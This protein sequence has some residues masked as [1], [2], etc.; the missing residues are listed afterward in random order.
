LLERI[1]F[2]QTPATDLR[3]AR[4]EFLRTVAATLPLYYATR[5]PTA[6]AAA[7]EA[8]AR[9]IPRQKNPD[10]LEFPFGTLKNF[11]TPNDLFYVRNHF[12]A[13]KL[14]AMTWRLQVEGHVEKP[15][16]LGYEELLGLPPS[17]LNATLECAGNGRAFLAPKTKGVQWEQGAVSTAAWTGVKLATLLERAGVKHDAVEVVLEGADHGEPSN[18]P[19]PPGGIHFARSLPLTKASS[20]SVLLAYKMNGATLPAL[21]GFPVRAVVGGWYGMASVKWLTRILVT[22]RPFHGYDQS[23]DY[24]IW[25]RVSGVPSLTP[26][27]QMQVKAAIAR[28]TVGEQ[29]PAHRKYRVHGA[30]W[31]GEADVGRVEVSTDGGTTWNEARLRGQALPLCWRLWDFSWT[32]HR[33]GKHAL[34]ARATDNRGNVQPMKHDPDRRNYMITKVQPC[35]VEVGS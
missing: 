25:E 2:M 8:E 29:I 1:F 3:R 14:Q 23:I 28:P 20:E 31:A 24:A 15:F 12:P 16:D 30:A 13:P 11:F 33:T 19:R 35:Q 6:L 26:I 22:D 7:E 32:P 27:T 4:R 5:L 9:L 34:M 17:T 18:E 10:N 21:H